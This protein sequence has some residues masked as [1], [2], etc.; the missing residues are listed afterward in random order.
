MTKILIIRFRR[1]GDSVISSTLCTS[2]KKSIPDAEIHYVLNENIAPLFKY[3]PDID[4]VITFSNQEMSSFKNYIYKV[5]CIMQSQKYDIIIDTR[6]TI[7]TLFFSLFSLQTKLRIG[8]KKW[9]NRLIHN[10]RVNNIYDGTRDN[11]QLT[12]ELIDPLRNKYN[13]IKDPHFKLYNTKEEIITYKNYMA[14]CGINFSKPIIVCGIA[15]R[16]KHKMWDKKK[17]IVV[18]QKLIQKYDAQLIFNYADTTEKE[19]VLEIENM[20]NNHPCIF[21]NI[22]A[23]NLRELICL[24]TNSSFFFG[25]EGG[26]RHI[27]QA[28]NIPSFAIY[29][30][31]TMK[32]NW[33]PNKSH[34][35]SGIELEDIIKE[36]S[37]YSNL[38]FED[39]YNLITVDD[40]W[41]QLDYAIMNN[42]AIKP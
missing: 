14:S 12:L 37:Q 8:R 29:P 40:V 18:L 20:M 15:T 7:K 25:I 41:N 10:Y 28:L 38:P 27:S 32:G 24:L 5:S 36:K 17:M 13:I 1:I 4:K 21:T 34:Q 6:S 3:H 26:T 9:Y 11:A 42:I 23:Q 31:K 30:P 19:I 16:L 2:L 39:Q 33:L 35:F 22:E